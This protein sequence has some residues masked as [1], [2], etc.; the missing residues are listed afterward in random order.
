M[1]CDDVTPLLLAWQLGACET[2]EREGIE[3]HLKGCAACF[4]KF[5]AIKRVNEDAAAFDERPSP[6]LKERLRARVKQARTPRRMTWVMGLA[7]AAAL[8]I[9]GVVGWRALERGSL[10]TPPAAAGN[11]L[12][13][14]DRPANLDVL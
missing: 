14:A 10:A 8:I 5:L 11:G 4:S 2:G 9:L 12:V 3:E 1:N 13:D 6:R 7:A